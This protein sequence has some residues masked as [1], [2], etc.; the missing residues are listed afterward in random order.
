MGGNEKIQRFGSSVESCIITPAARTINNKKE[1]QTL[2]DE[3][4]K[5]QDLCHSNHKQWHSP[6]KFE[7][8][9]P[10]YVPSCCFCCV[11]VI[12]ALFS[13][14]LLCENDILKFY[15]SSTS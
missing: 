11:F 8:S 5:Y 4:K 10:F 9:P 1:K 15:S 7:P 12:V 14:V 3:K 13:K 2:S 6:W